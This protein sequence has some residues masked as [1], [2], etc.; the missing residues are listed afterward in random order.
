MFFNV[1]VKVEVEEEDKVK[2]E[3]ERK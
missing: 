3:M 1:D 2:E